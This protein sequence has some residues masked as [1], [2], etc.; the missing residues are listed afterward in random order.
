[1]V[2]TSSLIKSIDVINSVAWR[3]FV[4]DAAPLDG[5]LA[6]TKNLSNELTRV[7][8]PS[9]LALFVDSLNNPLMSSTVKTLFVEHWKKL[10]RRLFS[11]VIN[12]D[13]S[14]FVRTSTSWT[15]SKVSI[16]STLF[17][18]V[19]SLIIVEESTTAVLPTPTKELIPTSAKFL[20]PDVWS[21]LLTGLTDSWYDIG[22]WIVYDNVW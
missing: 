1:M 16:A 20:R 8:F 7:K 18:V 10:E 3:T 4:V 6:W 19:K 15:K 12:L 14:G 22:L 13:L 17:S 9:V 2:Y 11:K 21:N 5:T